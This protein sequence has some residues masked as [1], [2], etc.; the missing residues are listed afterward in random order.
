VLFLLIVGHAIMDYALQSDAMAIEKNRH[1]IT[2]LQKAV[3]WYYW[4][5]AHS[6]CHGG[7]VWFITH[8]PFLALAETVIHWIID[9]AKSE[10]WTNI[11]ADQAL[12]VA[13]KIVWY[14]MIVYGVTGPIDSQIRVWT[15][16]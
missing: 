4:L 12:H 8:S 6:L 15:L 10:K 2:P 16:W 5:T 1:S 7:A 14:A 11:H 13:C 9:F 3:P